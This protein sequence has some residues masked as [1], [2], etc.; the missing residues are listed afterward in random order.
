M[1]VD[2]SAVV[3]MTKLAVQSTQKKKEKTHLWI[4][5]VDEFCSLLDLTTLHC[6]PNVHAS[7]YAVQVDS[8]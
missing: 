8:G 3:T 4:E 6:S 1:I 2:Q 5:I 7:I